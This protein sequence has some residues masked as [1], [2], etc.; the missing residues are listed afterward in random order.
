MGRSVKSP[1]QLVENLDETAFP[2]YELFDLERYYQHG[3]SPA[4]L[5][6]R[7][8]AFRCT[9]CPYRS[10]EGPCYRLEI[11]GAGGG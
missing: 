9:Y 5:T 6:K 1:R 3:I 10:L 7:G 4:I 2:A 8:C 11:S